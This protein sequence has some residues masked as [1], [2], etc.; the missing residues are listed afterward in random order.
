MIQKRKVII[1]CDPGIDDSLALMLAL[2]SEEIDVVGITIVCGN[3]PTNLGVE[4]AI[5][6]LKLMGRL[7][8]PVYA[9]AEV[10]LVREYISA[11]DTHGMDGLG[12][13][14][15]ENVTEGIRRSGAA[16]YLISM[17]L[18]EENLSIIALGPMTNIANAMSINLEAFRRVDQF[19]S[20]GGNY[21]SHGNC[22]PVAEY[23]YWCDPDGAKAVYE[24]M[25]RIDKKI[26]MVGLD[27]TREIVF[28]PSLASYAKRLDKQRGTFVDS[29]VQFYFDFHWEYEKIIGCVINDPLAIAYFI[30]P[31]LCQG[32]EA[33][34]TI[35]TEGISIG[36][37]VVDRMQF[38]KKPSNS[39]ILTKV[40][41][42]RFMEMFMQRVFGGS[43]EEITMQLEQMM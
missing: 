6:V 21:R 24:G 1:D 15:Y 34:T 2:T 38:W 18:Q 3:V 25:A 26:H 41:S 29:I 8:I 32:F 42:K 28:T 43:V 13:T 27:V 20:M 12:E 14:N 39:V 35:E 22:S 16:E 36:Q 19:V 4:N 9:G 5:K 33:Y 37:S 17:L 31:K 10:P 40:D 7:D 30:D 11:Q 23:N